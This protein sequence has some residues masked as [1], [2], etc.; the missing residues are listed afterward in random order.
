M[1]QISSMLLVNRKCSRLAAEIEVGQFI[2][3]V[4]AKEQKVFRL[5]AR[6]TFWAILR[7]VCPKLVILASLW[8]KTN[9]HWLG[10]APKWVGPEAAALPSHVK[11]ID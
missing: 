11:S 9:S 6:N 8:G 10:L 5:P 1:T 3:I 7:Q 2:E 4:I